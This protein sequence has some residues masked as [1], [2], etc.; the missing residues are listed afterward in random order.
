MTMT[1][2]MTLLLFQHEPDALYKNYNTNLLVAFGVWLS[3]VLSAASGGY[4]ID[5][6]NPSRM[7][8]IA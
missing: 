3:Y 2:T 1:L 7:I 8:K 6:S 5:H 4:H